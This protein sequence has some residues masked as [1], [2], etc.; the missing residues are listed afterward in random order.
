MDAAGYVVLR[1]HLTKIAL[2][3]LTANLPICPIGME[4]CSGTH[5]LGRALLAQGHEPRLMPPNYVKPYAK[6][7]KNDA[8]GGSATVVRNDCRA[9][10][11][12]GPRPC[13]FELDTQLNAEQARALELLQGIQI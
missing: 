4:A 9:K 13:G 12:L 6:R 1:R 5:H 7:E 11:E 10:G 3:R 2:L 8:A